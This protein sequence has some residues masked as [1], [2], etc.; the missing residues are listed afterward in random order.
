MNKA[1][2][3]LDRIT[4]S[5]WP[6]MAG[7]DYRVPRRKTAILVVPTKPTLP[8]RKPTV[9][10]FYTT[11]YLKILHGIQWKMNKEFKPETKRM[12]MIFM[13]NGNTIPWELSKGLLPLY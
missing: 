5:P 7:A 12:M 13:A 2:A 10:V 4:L 9:T 6:I 3:V 8:T 11:H 1:K